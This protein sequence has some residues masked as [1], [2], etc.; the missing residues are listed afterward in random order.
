[1]VFFPSNANQIVEN[2]FKIHIDSII[3]CVIHKYEDRLKSSS[4]NQDTRSEWA[5]SFNLVPHSA[6]TLL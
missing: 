4:T 3:Y 6:Y 1:M 5:L 2:S